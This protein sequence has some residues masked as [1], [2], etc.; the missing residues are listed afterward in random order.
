MG[1]LTG[2]FSI[3]AIIP[4]YNAEGTISEVIHELRSTNLDGK[5]IERII[6]VNNN[7]SDQTAARAREAE[8]LVV[9]E[10][11]LGF[12]AAAQRG[13]NEAEDSDVV[14][15]IDGDSS[16]LGSEWPRLV[17]PIANGE[18]ELVVGVRQTT[19][20]GAKLHWKER[21]VSRIAVLFTKFLYDSPFNDVCSFRAV[22]T[23][24]LLGLGILESASGWGLDMQLKA[25]RANL[26]VL[27]V[28][29]TYRSWS[30]GQSRISGVV[31]G[32]LSGLLKAL[33]LFMLESL[34]AWGLLKKSN[35]RE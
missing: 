13:V 17:W 7:S 25:L 15:F 16:F 22:K 5:G 33:R 14:L 3:V 30:F 20:S 32:D 4:A 31:R 18:A 8:S 29:V 11:Q 27:E 21:L 34:W 12:G 23:S 28:P 6:V 2:K 19:K 10:K 9:N 26:K 35:S 24:S 1:F